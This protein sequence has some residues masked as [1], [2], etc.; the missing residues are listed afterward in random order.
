MQTFLDIALEF[1]VVFDVDS[2]H[3]VSE[4]VFHTYIKKARRSGLSR[5]SFLLL[6]LGKRMQIAGSNGAKCR[7]GQSAS[8][9]KLCRLPLGRM[10]TCF[11]TTDLERLIVGSELR[12]RVLLL[13]AQVHSLILNQLL[14][15]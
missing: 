14:L 13:N 6:F 1:V 2:A 4:D 15:S 12:R 7:I 10:D 8:S 9:A 11:E 3:V 5:N